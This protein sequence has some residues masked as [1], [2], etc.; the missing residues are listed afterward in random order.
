MVAWRMTR[1]ARRIGVILLSLSVLGAATPAPMWNATGHMITASIADTR[2]EPAVKA[3]VDRLIELLAQFE[4][5]FADVTPAATWM[6]AIKGFDEGLLAFND[7]HYFDQP[8][9]PMGL[10]GV[11]QPAE[12]NVVW[13]IGQAASTLGSARAEDFEKALML[14]ML[15]HFVGDLHQPLHMINRITMEH[16]EGDFGGNLFDL[17]GGEARSLHAYWDGTA[18]LFPHVQ[19]TDTSWYPIRDF[20]RR[21]A[22]EVAPPDA[23]L[24]TPRDSARV[25]PWIESNARE[26]ALES[27]RH[28]MAAYEGITPGGYPDAA[29][30]GRAQAVVRER[31][32]W[33][34][35]RLAA[36]LNAVVPEGMSERGDD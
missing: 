10:P 12:Q 2:M 18:A 34:G 9:N 30:E 15:I 7:W 32:A 4:P 27:Y 33:G 6:D 24:L 19:A 8:Y 13:A 21:I 26:W 35:Y 20:A 25:G 29:Y 31:L 3:E 1:A 17:S 22:Q 28:G 23:T 36:I 16:P 5:S 14:R 11:E